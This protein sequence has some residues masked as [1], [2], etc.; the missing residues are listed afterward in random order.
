MSLLI[1]LQEYDEYCI[2]TS[3]DESGM[4]DLYLSPDG[5]GKVYEFS[6]YPEPNDV[7]QVIKVDS[8]IRNVCFQ[9]YS[10]YIIIVLFIHFRSTQL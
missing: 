1:Y 8:P 6:F 7:N 5:P 4:N 9:K 2:V 3:N 10:F